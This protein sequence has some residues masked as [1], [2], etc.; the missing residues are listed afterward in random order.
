MT[1]RMYKYF[2]ND[3]YSLVL[4]L[5]RNDKL[6]TALLECERYLSRFPYDVRACARYADILMRLGK[7]TEAEEVLNNVIFTSKTSELFKQDVVFNKLKLYTYLGQYD[8]SLE[9][10]RDNFDSLEKRGSDVTQILIFLK[11]KLGLLMCDNYQ[12]SGYK[13]EQIVNYSEEEAIKC[14]TR[15]HGNTPNNSSCYFNENFPIKDVYYK[16]RKML[17]LETKAYEN[18][19]ENVYFFKYLNNGIANSSKADYIK[20]Y[21][22]LGTP[23]II[24]MY[25]FNLK[26]RKE[27]IDLTPELEEL[28]KVK[29]LSQIDKFNQKY[30]KK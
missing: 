14:I 1:K 15:C 17:P 22:T 8:K 26:E 23:D 16:I 18:V 19:I 5:V 21:A 28:H 11:K 29:K 10:L 2:D 12:G 25:P 27:C 7:F 4:Q 30:G 9:I 6:E 24:T 3:D 20:V 13:I